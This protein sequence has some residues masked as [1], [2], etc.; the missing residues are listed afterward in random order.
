MEERICT[1]F[2][3]IIN[4]DDLGFPR[5]AGQP[6]FQGGAK[7]GERAFFIVRGDNQAERLGRGMV[8]DERRE[9]PLTL[10]FFRG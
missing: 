10:G 1:I 4:D 7:P 8:H 6:D 9:T 2:R 5:L 3:S